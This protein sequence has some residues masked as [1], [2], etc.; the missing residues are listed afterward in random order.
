MNRHLNALLLEQAALSLD[1]FA[2]GCAV[3]REWVI[4]HVE[5]GVLVCSGHSPAHWS[6]A[7]Q[8]LRRARQLRRLERDFDANP[9]LAG[10]VVDLIEELERVRARLRR[11][12]LE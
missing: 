4:A 10:L 11:V 1:E 7:G 8:D 6:F 12:G 9:E 2:A 3:N 5:A